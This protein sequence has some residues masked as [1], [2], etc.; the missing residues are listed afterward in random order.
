MFT[1][2]GIAA[3]D[4]IANDVDETIDAT[5][6]LMTLN[7]GGANGTTTLFVQP[8]GGDGKSGCNLTGSTT[9]GVSVASSNPAVATVSISNSTFTACGDT[10]IV[11][12]TPVSAGT[13][14]VTVSQ[15]SNNTGATF[16]FAPATFT[17]NVAAPANTAPQVSVTGVTNGA[18]Y[19]VGDVP[20]PGCSVTDAEDGPSNPAPT[21]TGTLDPDGLGNVTTTCSYTDTGGLTSTVSATYSIV[22][23]SAPEISY[24]ISP[25]DPDGLD[26]WW[27]GS[28]VLDW[29]VAE[30]D[31]PRSLALDGCE[32]VTITAD[33]L[34]TEYTCSA[35]SSGGTAGPVSVTIKR[36]GNAPVVAYD[37]ATGT[38]GDNGW[39]VGDVTATFTATD[40]FSGVAGSASATATS[41]GDGHAVSIGN[42]AFTDRAGNTTVADVVSSPGFKIDTA[43]P[44]VGDADLSGTEGN[45]GW[46]T[47]DVSAS[48]TATDATSGVASTNPG[49][50]TSGG[51]QGSMTLHSPE[52]RDL[53]GNVTGS[54]AKSVAVKVDSVA[55]SV[56]LVDGPD[57]GSSHYFG[58]VPAAPTCEA[59]D[60]TSGIA[61]P[62]TV[63]GYA[64][65]VGTHTV[66]ATVTDEAGN[67]T[68]VSRTYTVNAW[69]AQG[70]YSPVDMNGVW[71][72]VK[73]GS[74]VPLKFE[75]F[76][77]T[78]ELTSIAS[79]KSF[80]YRSVQCENMLASDEIEMLTSGSTSLRYDVTGGQ[81]IQNWKVPTAVGCYRATMTA[82]D[83]TAIEALFKVTK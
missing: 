20:P 61:E 28:P 76:A 12:V 44:T 68:T 26:G 55:P 32:D 22:D 75:L 25:P 36:D 56:N 13:T 30:G 62:C 66:T 54:G 59:S 15:T 42:P 60:A 5:A 35:T 24:T 41:S 53:A 34:A 69:T 19:Q 23:Q 27:T 79:I 82:L 33:Q 2:A 37:S 1:S 43:A 51:A 65:G 4:D 6:E 38:P 8:T 58:S 78:N 83:G 47:S 64:T 17:V 70:F 80:N 29:T 40:G 77:G 3:A 16:N 7:V 45:D 9:L 57:D 63:S 52:F 11:N 74:T 21:I 49:I 50:V 67:T 71:N 14:T 72:K 81:F 48:F 18:S 39:Y 73:G 31:S 10:K 46:Y